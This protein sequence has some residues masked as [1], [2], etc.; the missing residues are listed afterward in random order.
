MRYQYTLQRWI[1][2]YEIDSFKRSSKIKSYP[3]FEADFL[4]FYAQN[5]RKTSDFNVSEMVGIILK[6]KSDFVSPKVMSC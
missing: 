5:K 1:V 2:F 3:E 6:L 4:R